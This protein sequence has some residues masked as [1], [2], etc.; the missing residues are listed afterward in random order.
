VAHPVDNTGHE[1]HNDLTLF[2]SRLETRSPTVASHLG[3]EN[4]QDLRFFGLFCQCDPHRKSKADHV[5]VSQTVNPTWKKVGEF[6]REE[7]SHV[8]GVNEAVDVIELFTKVVRGC[9][10]VEQD[11]TPADAAYSDHLGHRLVGIGKVV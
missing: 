5:G 9:H 4:L 2:F 3:P 6:T 11:D 10:E 7:G 1:G 8:G